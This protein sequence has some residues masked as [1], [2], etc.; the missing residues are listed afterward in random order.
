MKRAYPLQVV[1]KGELVAM[2]KHNTWN[3][4]TSL[5]AA[6]LLLLKYA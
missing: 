5:Q 4:E 6:D 3:F 1:H 2:Q